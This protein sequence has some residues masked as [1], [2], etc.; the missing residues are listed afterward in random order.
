LRPKTTAYG[1]GPDDFRELLCDDD[2]ARPR[3]ISVVSTVISVTAIRDP[4]GG[5]KGVAVMPARAEM[6]PGQPVTFTMP[7]DG[8]PRPPTC[9]DP[10]I[11]P[12]VGSSSSV[13]GAGD[14]HGENLGART[15]RR[16]DIALLPLLSLLYLFNGLDRSNIGNAQT[17]GMRHLQTETP[18]LS[19]ADGNTCFTNDIGC[20]PDD[21]NLAVSLFYLTFVLFQPI[22]AGVGGWVGPKHWIPFMMVSEPI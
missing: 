19:R 4:W 17:Q 6:R 22:S 8:A 1:H 21:F 20:Q 3:P 15:N 14:D 7:R 13:R 18:I 11:A 16:I 2:E 9:R 12:A 5:Q 10:L